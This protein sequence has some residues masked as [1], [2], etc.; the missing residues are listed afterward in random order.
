MPS[1]P[2]KLEKVGDCIDKGIVNEKPF[3]P[4]IEFY[5]KGKTIEYLQVK[6][7]QINF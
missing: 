6:F 2:T 7:L 5:I 1:D 4:V 3:A